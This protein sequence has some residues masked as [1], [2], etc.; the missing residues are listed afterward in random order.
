[1]SISLNTN[2]L[3][4]FSE[5]QTVSRTANAKPLTILM[6]DRRLNSVSNWRRQNALATTELCSY[7]RVALVRVAE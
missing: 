3:C 2:V 7:S 4:L 6:K 5:Q 1:M